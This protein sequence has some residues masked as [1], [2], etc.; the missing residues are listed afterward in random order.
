M[1]LLFKLAIVFLILHALFRYGV[2][3]VHYQQFKDAVEETALFAKN[4]EESEILARVMELAAEYDIPLDRRFVQVRRQG[5]T[6]VV[7][8]AYV[9]EIEWLPTWKKPMEFVIGTEAWHVRQPTASDFR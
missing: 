4:K 6:T 2:V 5:D 8:A 7:D 3:Y 9:E 1:R